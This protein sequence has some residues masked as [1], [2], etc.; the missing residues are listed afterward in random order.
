[1]ICP[2]KV[3]LIHGLPHYRGGLFHLT[4]R[5][6]FVHTKTFYKF[7]SIPFPHS[8]YADTSTH[9]LWFSPAKKKQH[10]LTH[11]HIISQIFCSFSA[12]TFSKW[13]KTDDGD[14]EKMFRS[15]PRRFFFVL[16]TQDF[17]FYFILTRCLLN[18]G[19]LLINAHSIY[20][21]TLGTFSITELLMFE[22]NLTS[23]K[24]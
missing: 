2:S 8:I 24:A 19:F 17:I 7:C 9:G 10:K 14:E 16:L 20:V 12:L 22:K 6:T 3:R 5:N 11:S 21:T 15:F 1:M 4:S 13:K 18:D 23:R